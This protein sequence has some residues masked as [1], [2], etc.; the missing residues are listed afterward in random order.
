M[1]R[2]VFTNEAHRPL[3]SLISP[4]RIALNLLQ[5]RELIAA[6]TKREFQAVH[7]GTYLGLAWSV[8]SPLIL[9]GLFVWVFGFIFGGRFTRNPN[10]TP[11]EFA[12]ALFIGMSFFNCFAQSM[13]GASGLVLGNSI[14]VKSLSFPLE[15]L[16]VASVLVTLVNLLIALSIC[17]LAQ[18][19]IYGDLHWTTPWLLTHIVCIALLSLGISWFVS[20]LSVFVRDIPPLIPP[21]SLVLMFVSGVFFPLSNISPRIRWLI[22]LNPLAVI[23]DQARGALMYGQV[24]DVSSLTIVA[25]CSLLFAI[26]SYWFFIRAKSAF[27]DVM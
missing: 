22:E 25:I 15:I 13:G 20:S 3:S 10:E 14:Y 11:A 18:F 6:Y 19:A 8:I 24:P 27:A 21:L 2:V 12:L 9:L 16:S 23:I 5:H 7:R 26:A 4:H 17:I 1:S